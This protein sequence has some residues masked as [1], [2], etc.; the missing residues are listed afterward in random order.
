MSDPACAARAAK[1][2][3]APQGAHSQV[4]ALH[5]GMNVGVSRSAPPN[6]IIEPYRLR[7]YTMTP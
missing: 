1:E 3:R 6:T 4:T 2:I 7:L 5:N